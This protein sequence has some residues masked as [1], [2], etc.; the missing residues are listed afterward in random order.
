MR[1]HLVGV[2]ADEA[3]EPFPRFRPQ[4]SEAEIIENPGGTYGRW[5]LDRGASEHNRTVEEEAAIH[6]WIRDAHEVSWTP[7]SE[8][9]EI[10]VATSQE[11]PGVRVAVN[12]PSQVLFASLIGTTI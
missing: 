1:D 12:K 8:A 11:Y 2:R 7:L 9:P 10:G 3:Q 6:K 5:C 4:V